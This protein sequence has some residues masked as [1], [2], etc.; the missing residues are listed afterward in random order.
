MISFQPQ[1]RAAIRLR[2]PRSEKG[3]SNYP[4]GNLIDQ[5]EIP[6]IQTTVAMVGLGES[7]LM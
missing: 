5:A 6:V 1:T 2:Q 3:I 7:V 4:S